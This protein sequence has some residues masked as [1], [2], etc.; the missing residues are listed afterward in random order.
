MSL[1]IL[2]FFSSAKKYI[3]CWKEF[4]WTYCEK[5]HIRN[6]KMQIA[7]GTVDLEKIIT[8]KKIACKVCHWYQNVEIQ[9]CTDPGHGRCCVGAA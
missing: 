8:I 3:Y 7:H 9:P 5:V 6:I 4:Q 2:V 1:F